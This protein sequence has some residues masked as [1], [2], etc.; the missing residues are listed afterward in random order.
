M[1]LAP[2]VRMI[3]RMPEPISN[4]TLLA[5]SVYRVHWSD[6]ADLKRSIVVVAPDASAAIAKARRHLGWTYQGPSGQ[7]P[8]EAF[9][10]S[11]ESN[12]GLFGGGVPP[13]TAVIRIAEVDVL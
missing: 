6:V 2:G 5:M 11:N 3:V 10:T 13:I 9:Q 4:G 8:D 7:R 1:T 12:R